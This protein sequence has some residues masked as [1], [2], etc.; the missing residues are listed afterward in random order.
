MLKIPAQ[1]GGSTIAMPDLDK[2]AEPALGQAGFRA[3]IL[4][5]A[6]PSKLCKRTSSH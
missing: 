5:L 3:R 6:R 1:S 2:P 4:P